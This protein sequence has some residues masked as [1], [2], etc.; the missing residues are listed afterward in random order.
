MNNIQDIGIEGLSTTESDMEFIDMP[1]RDDAM[2]YFSVC[3][4]VGKAMGLVDRQLIEHGTA[5]VLFTKPMTLS[6]GPR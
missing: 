6:T 2:R 1:Y 3:P 4:S 5:T